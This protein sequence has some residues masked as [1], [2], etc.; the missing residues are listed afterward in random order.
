MEKMIPFI[1]NQH[2]V[3]VLEDME[4]AKEISKSLN[5]KRSFS[6]MLEDCDV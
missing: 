4:E 2:K 1:L 5:V 6:K 3:G